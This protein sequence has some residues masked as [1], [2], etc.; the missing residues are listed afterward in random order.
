MQKRTRMVIILTLLPT[1]LLRTL[2]SGPPRM[3]IVPP[4]RLQGM[5]GRC[6]PASAVLKRAMMRLHTLPCGH[7]CT[8]KEEEDEDERWVVTTAQAKQNKVEGAPFIHP[9]GFIG[10]SHG[11]LDVHQ[12]YIAPLL[13]PGVQLQTLDHFQHAR[14]AGHR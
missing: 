1:L 14:H 11:P 5:R 7:L 10:Y 3:A 9:L 6:D 2:G 8:T 13:G 4:G 12:G